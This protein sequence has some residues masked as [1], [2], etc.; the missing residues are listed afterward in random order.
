MTTI[1]V[2]GGTGHVGRPVAERLRAD[3]RQVRLLVRDA[4]R[5]RSM[6]GD[7]FELFS[8]SIEDATAV[9]AAMRGVDGVHVSVTGGT[10]AEMMAAEAVGMATVAAEAAR[11]RVGLVTYVSGNL[12][13]EDYGP[14]LPEHRAKIIA[15]DALK[16]SGV[17][18]VI[19]RPTYFMENLT[20]HISGRRA[21][22][23]GHPRPLHMVAAADFGSMVSR[24]YD[25][26][27]V[28]NQELVVHGPEPL[29]I[30]QALACYRDV[31][32]PEL[33]CT[34]VPVWAMA[35]ANHLVLRGSLTGPIQLMRLLERIGE[36]GD[37]TPCRQHLGA[38]TTTLSEWCESISTTH[39]VD[40]EAEGVA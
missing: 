24:A 26:P 34:T 3:G 20:R 8:G 37:P 36:C 4:A 7:G 32:R 19:F 6:L 17:P 14:K 22:T 12:A 39:R 23:I 10:V 9:A 11:A 30:Q 38:A 5:A 31:A 25:T 2:V 21:I 18:Y 28:H 40:A 1:L 35:A 15:E 33:R 13:R 16:A 27:A 29:T